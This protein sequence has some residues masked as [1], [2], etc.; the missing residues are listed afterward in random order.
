MIYHPPTLY[1]DNVSALLLSSVQIKINID[2]TE[3]Y[4]KVTNK[5]S[6][7]ILLAVECT[8]YFMIAYMMGTDI[9][10][11]RIFLHTKTVAEI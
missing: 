8:H 7:A 2:M 5:Q 10:T 3:N 1:T 11:T 9:R 4:D 6:N